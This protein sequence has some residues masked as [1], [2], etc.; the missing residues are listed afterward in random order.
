MPSPG[1]SFS[2]PAK[3]VGAILTGSGFHAYIEACR[4][5]EM[6]QHDALHAAASILEHGIRKYAK[7]RKGMLGVDVK[8]AASKIVRPIR[9]A[10]NMHAQAAKALSTSW[11]NYQK[12]LGVPDRKTPAGA[13]DPT[14]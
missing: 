5:F 9:H 7:G 3:N 4:A 6:V 1:R 11:L 10:A 8:L 2:F 12:T 13:F 14:K